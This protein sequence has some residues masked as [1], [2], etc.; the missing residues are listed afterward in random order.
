MDWLKNAARDAIL[1][2]EDLVAGLTAVDL[3]LFAVGLTAVLW[4]FARARATNR[5][6]PVEVETF[7][8]DAD[9]EEA[10]PGD[11]PIHDTPIHVL[12][13]RLRERLADTGLSPPPL[14]P[15][16]APQADLIAAVETSGAPQAAWIAALI[17]MIPWP[18]VTAFKLSGTLIATDQLENPTPAVSVWLRP[19]TTGR[20]LLATVKGS[21]YREAVDRA[22]E[23]VFMHISREATGVFP[24]WARW[25]RP[26]AFRWYLEGIAALGNRKL[27][28][29]ERKLRVACSREPRNLLARLRLINLAEIGLPP[30]VLGD[31]NVQNVREHADVLRRYLDLAVERPDFVEP[32]YRASLLAGVIASACAGEVRGGKAEIARRVGLEGENVAEALRE[33]A[34]RES[35]AVLQLVRGWYVPLRHFR[36]R[37]RYEP[38]GHDRR[39]LHRSVAISGHCLG[40]RAQLGPVSHARLITAISLWRRR[41]VVWLAHLQL[42]RGSVG[43]QSHYNAACFYALLD[44]REERVPSGA[45]GGPI[46]FV[47]YRDPLERLARRRAAFRR[48]AYRHLNRAIE[49]EEGELSADW[50]E[51]SD[52]DLVSLRTSGDEAWEL[53]KIRH[54]GTGTHRDRQ[55]AR[56]WGSPS[57]RRDW[58]LA[59]VVAGLAIT[60]LSAVMTGLWPASTL[61]LVPAFAVWRMRRAQREVSVEEIASAAPSVT[62][63]PGD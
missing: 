30:V 49:E 54:R 9:G 19:T 10:D 33:L 1:W 11:T 42:G 3:V 59:V 26:D 24:P 12:T 41:A 6:G 27:P 29:A 40:V 63:L 35:E 57:T 16:G 28:E 32:R 43:W 25:T 61:G 21:D 44:L 58:W 50:L 13:A 8:H 36:L 45:L 34:A 48:A 15:A 22:A 20:D 51:K 56:P 47:R 38:T 17:E 53:V 52:P 18:Q 14:V 55:P 2:I 23:R 60:L 46:G 39:L 37:H 4:A 31:G 5:L 62:G 7:V